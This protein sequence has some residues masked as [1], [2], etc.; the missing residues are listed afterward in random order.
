MARCDA[1]EENERHAERNSEKTHFAQ[2]HAEHR[3]QREHDD[4]L[5]GRM[6]GK[7]IRK[8]VH[9]VSFRDCSGCKNSCFFRMEMCGC[10]FLPDRRDGRAEYPYCQGRA[11]P[12]DHFRGEGVW[13]LVGKRS[14]RIFGAGRPASSR[15]VSPLARRMVRMRSSLKKFIYIDYQYIMQ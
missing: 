6:L 7:K 9:F 1:D 4:G 5:N 3:D 13:R 12:S 11:Y 10:L 14:L 15:S 2:H 8:P